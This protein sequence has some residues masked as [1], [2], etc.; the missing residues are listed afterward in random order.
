MTSAPSQA[1][2]AESA[3]PPR[4]VLEFRDAELP[5]FT[6]RYDALQ[7]VNLTLCAGDCALVVTGPGEEGLPLADAA[8]GLIVPRAGY[9][10]IMGDE[11]TRLGPREQLVRRGRIGRVFERPGWINNL[12]VL[13]NVLLPRRHH[14]DAADERLLGDARHWA[15]R[16]G[17]EGVPSERPSSVP[18][19]QLRLAE[20]VRAFSLEPVLLLLEYP[21]RGVPR[22]RFASL[23]SAVTEARCRGA[24]VLWLV[25]DAQEVGL[26]SGSGVMRFAVRDRTLKAT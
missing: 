2:S 21:L 15:E 1:D 3:D 17:L 7:R 4:P 11:W 13:D 5:P 25:N 19:D 16:F 22:E 26:P 8:S 23:L 18:A 10:R 6:R 20:W 12:N 14:T 24:A 9:V